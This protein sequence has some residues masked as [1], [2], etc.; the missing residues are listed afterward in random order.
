MDGLVGCSTQPR[1]YDFYQVSGAIIR[2]L[3]REEAGSV[4]PS[5]VNRVTLQ[6]AEN[7]RI[8]IIRHVVC[9]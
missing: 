8:L 7:T 5:S 4:S 3:G 6:T 1:D 9:A 2:I